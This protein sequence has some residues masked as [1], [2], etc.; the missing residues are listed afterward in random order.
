MSGQ[1]HI[2]T[3]IDTCL[4][5]LETLAHNE[6]D[7]LDISA[8]YGLHVLATYGCLDEETIRSLPKRLKISFIVG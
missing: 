6:T 3:A 7:H 2:K 4:G 8:T 5:C 1:F